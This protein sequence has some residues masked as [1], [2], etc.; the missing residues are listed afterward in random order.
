MPWACLAFSNGGILAY[1]A[2]AAPPPASD[3]L[4][5]VDRKGEAQPITTTLHAY[6]NP[7]VLPDGKRIVVEVRDQTPGIWLRDSSRDTLS[8]LAI[9]GRETAPVLTPDGEH[10]I[11]NSIRNG[12][13]GLWMKRVDGS[14]AEENFTATTSLQLPNSVSPDGTSVAYTATTASESHLLALP[15]HGPHTP[16]PLLSGPGNRAAASYSP[17]GRWI[18]YVSDESG[19]S[20]VYVSAASGQGATWPISSAGGAEPVWARSGRELFY[21]AGRTMMAVPVQSGDAFSIGRAVTLFEGD[22]EH[23]DGV[24]STLPDYDVSPDGLRFVMLQRT[25][26]AA[27]AAPDGLHLV[28]N[29]FQDLAERVAADKR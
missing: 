5:W 11:F 1:L 22:F 12:S 17:D 8:P 19:R 27:A 23:N 6:A 2:E 24:Q 26:P 10:V 25:G 18:A 21:R 3:R 7:R 15:L 14:G 4:V 16:Q 13:E 9:S 29:W 20:E 28:L